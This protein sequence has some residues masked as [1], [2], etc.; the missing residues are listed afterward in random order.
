VGIKINEERVR[1]GLATVKIVVVGMV[2]SEDRLPISTTR[3]RAGEID[4]EGKLT[5]KHSSFR[6]RQ[7]Q[8]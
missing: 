2:P 4:T 8:R 5:K 7:Q 1:R 6:V 3:I